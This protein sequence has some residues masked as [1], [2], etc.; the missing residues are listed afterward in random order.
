MTTTATL[1]QAPPPA[2]DAGLVPYRVTVRQFLKM[3]DAGV[4][5]PESRI[6]LLGGLLVEKM[7]KGDP[8]D[9]AT[10]RLGSL[11]RTILL[12][13]GWVIREEKSVQLGRLWR[14]EPDVAVVRG[15]DDRY[16]KG[17]PGPAD[18][19]LIV[20]V[21]DATYE[22]DRGGKWHGYARAGVPL[23]WIV[24]LPARQVEVYTNPTGHD[25]EARYQ[26]QTNYD[27]S[28]EVPVSIDG[29]EVGR[30][31]VRELLA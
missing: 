13:A 7:T 12:P 21:S 17:S 25:T 30:V 11:L 23:Y 1:T 26:N 5:P 27:E 16:R 20:E 15:P 31:A 8:H 6:E 10:T 19:A 18:I 4:F 9:F 28:A 29:R 3:I 24:N 2:A 14:P 22:K